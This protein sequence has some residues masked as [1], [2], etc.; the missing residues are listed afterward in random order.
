MVEGTALEKRH[1]RKGIESSNLSL[2]A[3][4]L[5]TKSRFQSILFPL[6]I[7]G[8]R[9][10]SQRKHF[11]SR[12][13]RALLITAA[14]AVTIP[15]SAGTTSW[16]NTSG[17]M[18][19]YVPVTGTFT[20]SAPS[21]YYKS[22]VNFTLSAGNVSSINGYIQGTGSGCSG[23]AA[24]LT[25]TT[26]DVVRMTSYQALNA[27]SILTTLPNPKPS[28]ENLSGNARKETARLTAASAVQATSYYVETTWIDDRGQFKSNDQG[29]IYATFGMAK[30]SGTTYSDC[31]TSSQPQIMN[32]HSGMPGAL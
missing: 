6:T 19:A 2:S 7:F 20:E 12:S 23:S 15:V 24:Y 17:S 9:S 16:D 29:Y 3:A 1:T 10:L 14:C 4:D 13:F 11:M 25:L 31:V 5:L 8:E 32:S 22:K 28:L 18:G 27:S 26:E 30:L 21:G